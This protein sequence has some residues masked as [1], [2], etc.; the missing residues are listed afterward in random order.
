M[1]NK[2]YVPFETVK[3]NTV[4]VKEQ[5][6]GISETRRDGRGQMTFKLKDEY[7]G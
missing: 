5:V 7:S 3:Q 4:E 2:E 1:V 6:L